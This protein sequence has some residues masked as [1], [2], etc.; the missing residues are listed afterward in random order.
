[1]CSGV[2]ECGFGGP[3]HRSGRL[4]VAVD[5]EEEEG[6]LP[7]P[8][9]SRS[10]HPPPHLGSCRRDP[11]RC[12]IDTRAGTYR[13]LTSIPLNPHPLFYCLLPPS[14]PGPLSTYRPA[15][16][17]HPTNPQPYA[18][19]SY[20][21]TPTLT[22]KGIEGLSPPKAFRLKDREEGP[23]EDWRLFSPPWPLPSFHLYSIVSPFSL[24][25]FHS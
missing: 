12:S 1:M 14:L 3:S 2:V 23:R 24:S 11:H 13:Y 19:S 9:S 21:S 5:G 16:T 20:L 18:A 17:S 22:F 4:C 6:G 25:P 15:K 8:K 7:P 10:P